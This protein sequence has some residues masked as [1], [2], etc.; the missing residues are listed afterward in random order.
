MLSRRICVLNFNWD[1]ECRC[2]VLGVIYLLSLRFPRSVKE[3]IGA[4]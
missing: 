2:K 3:Y 1:N 4:V